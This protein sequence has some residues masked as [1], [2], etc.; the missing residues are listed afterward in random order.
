MSREEG[1]MKGTIFFLLLAVALVGCRGPVGPE[2]PI[3]TLP[4]YITGYVDS[5]FGGDTTSDVRVEVSNVSGLPAVYVNDIKIPLDI[6]RG[7]YRFR[8]YDFPISAGDSARLRVEHAKYD[9]G[10][11]I[12]QADVKLPGHFMI[13]SHDTSGIDTIPFGNQLV[14]TWNSSEGADLYRAG[15]RFFCRYR[16]TT[17]VNQEF[18]LN[19]D[20]LFADTSIIFASSEI[21]PDTTV[22]DSLI[23]YSGDFMISSLSGPWQEGEPGNVTGDGIGSFHGW[24]DGAILRFYAVRN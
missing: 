15:V 9:G 7:T 17:D 12:S 21:F 24:T 2:G 8:D 23:Y 20:T 22:V 5:P 13:T 18:Y 10:L 14:I 4:V 11:G 1:A 3:G 6:Y 19:L 16:D